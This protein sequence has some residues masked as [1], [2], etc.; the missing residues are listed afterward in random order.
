MTPLTNPPGLIPST[1]KLGYA[2]RE[3]LERVCRTCA[4]PCDRPIKIIGARFSVFSKENFVVVLK[5]A[6][7]LIFGFWSTLPVILQTLFWLSL[8][9]AASGVLASSQRRTLCHDKAWTGAKKKAVMWLVIMSG[10]LMNRVVNVGFDFS[11][12]LGIY[13]IITEM[14][15]VIRNARRAGLYVPP[16]VVDRLRALQREDRG[17]LDKTKSSG[18]ES[19]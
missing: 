14:L 8:I 15:S 4:A 18:E 13:F 5:A 10:V 2:E 1:I 19:L 12:A 9:D 17:Q 6:A 11:L 16:W 7:G 3:D